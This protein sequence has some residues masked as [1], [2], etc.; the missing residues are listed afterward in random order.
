MFEFL[1][2]VLYKPNPNIV[3]AN[4]ASGITTNILVFKPIILY[5]LFVIKLS[6]WDGY[7]HN[8]LI[9]CFILY[10]RIVIFLDFIQYFSLFSVKFDGS[11]IIVNN[12]FVVGSCN[13]SIISRG[14]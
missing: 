3:A 11:T 2:S 10:A 14:M 4:I 5:S 9:H 13:R 8:I 6:Q 12:P 1:Q 7:T